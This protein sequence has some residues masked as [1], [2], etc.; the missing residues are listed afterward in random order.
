MAVPKVVLRGVTGS[1]HLV[2]RRVG[3][4]NINGWPVYKLEI[5]ISVHVEQC[6]SWEEES[7]HRPDARKLASGLKSVSIS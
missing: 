4:S 3:G 1:M 7:V 2:L 6:S 5:V